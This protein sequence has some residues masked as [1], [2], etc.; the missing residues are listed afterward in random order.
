M[1]VL[2]LSLFATAVL[3]GCGTLNQSRKDTEIDYANTKGLMTRAGPAAPTSA[4][5]TAKVVRVRAPVA[6]LPAQFEETVTLSRG[7][8]ATL[9]DLMRRVGRVVEAPIR[10]T[11]EVEDFI[12]AKSAGSQSSNRPPIVNATGSTL[13]LAEDTGIYAMSFSGSRRALLDVVASRLGVSWRYDKGVVVFFLT[14]TRTFFIPALPASSSSKDSSKPGSTTGSATNNGGATS[15][16]E[17]TSTQS[18]WSDIEKTIR[19]MLTS[20]GRVIVSPTSGSVVVTDMPDS[21]ER[22]AKFVESQNKFLSRQVAMEVQVFNLTLSDDRSFGVDLNLASQHLARYGV[23][24]SSGA[25]QALAS[26]TSSAFAFSVLDTATGEAAKWRGSSLLLNAL[27]TQGDI[28]NMRTANLVSM[29]NHAVPLRIG[30]TTGYLAQSTV[31]TTANVGTS[32]SLSPGTIAEGYS[33]SLLPTILEDDAVLMQ[34]TVNVSQL[35]QL[36]S[37][38]SG[39]AKIEVPET[40]DANTL[41]RVVLKNGE[42]LMLA[43]FEQDTKSSADNIGLFGMG[44]KGARGRTLMVVLVTP[45]VSSR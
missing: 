20:A 6:T 5:P 4:A 35:R 37:I 15:E 24:L 39:N 22:V 43:G 38:I 9:E 11:R 26:G 12:K 17:V 21:L 34:L 3:A 45:K 32:T 23:S 19:S 8:I 44:T 28:S 18:I 25:G 2:V 1:K 30:R 14:D 16:L 7:E 13:S 40:E 31:S 29:N 33:L 10:L 42:T 41:Q 36:R 27:Q